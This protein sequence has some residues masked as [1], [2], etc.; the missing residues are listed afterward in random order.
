[1][2]FSH[3]MGRHGHWCA[4]PL[5]CLLIFLLANPFKP[6]LSL[7]FGGM[8]L[9]VI[10]CHWQTIHSPHLNW[11][12]PGT[13]KH[14][15]SVFIA[16][17]WQIMQLIVLAD[18]CAPVSEWNSLYCISIFIACMHDTSALS[19]HAP[20]VRH[21]RPCPNTVIV[22]LKKT[23]FIYLFLMDMMCPS[24]TDLKQDLINQWV[25]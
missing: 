20:M 21:L 18:V 6:C 3:W 7:L 19:V 23:I 14:P 16:T 15:C 8:A 25:I 4:C 2:G 17:D 5:K 12:Q 22:G 24:V 13:I 9:Y 10:I 1:M 11:S